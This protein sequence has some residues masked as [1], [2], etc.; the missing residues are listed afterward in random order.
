M[1]QSGGRTYVD[2]ERA[3]KAF[4][5]ELARRRE[6]MMSHDKPE[7]QVAWEFLTVAEKAAWLEAVNA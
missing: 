4:C 6:S 7:A 5:A 2:A 1:G 3:Y